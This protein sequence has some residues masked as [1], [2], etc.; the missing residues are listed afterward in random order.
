MKTGSQVAMAGNAAMSLLLLV[1]KNRLL[2][3]QLLES[4]QLV[5]FMV[6][7]NIDLP[8]NVQSILE[9]YYN[10]NFASLIPN[11]INMIFPNSTNSSAPNNTTANTHL[12]FRQMQQ[13]TKSE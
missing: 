2:L 5:S 6:Y 8:S 3:Y 1:N 13:T 4:C 10:A 12:N 7:L 9:M 11:P